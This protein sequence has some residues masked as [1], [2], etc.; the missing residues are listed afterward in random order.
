MSIKES[1]RA[2]GSSLLWSCLQRHPVNLLFFCKAKP[3]QRIAQCIQTLLGL[4][5]KWGEDRCFQLPV[6]GISC[7]PQP[8][9]KISTSFYWLQTQSE[10][11]MDYDLGPMEL[12]RRSG[13]RLSGM[14]LC[15]KFGVVS[16]QPSRPSYIYGCCCWVQPG[17]QVFLQLTAA[18]RV[19]FNW[20]TAP[21]C[22]T[23]G[24]GWHGMTCP[25]HYRHHKGHDGQ[26]NLTP[27][28]WTASL[29][30]EGHWTAG[31]CSKWTERC[32]AG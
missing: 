26:H 8:T 9:Y 24:F 15:F 1:K 14:P 11:Q 22:G 19:H 16:L 18:S 17:H 25:L 3:L 21:V 4:Q 13:M 12:H 6:W 23:S 2:Y 20:L 7:S 10:S 31:S 5:S 30:A 28:Q 27:A 29:Y 32:F